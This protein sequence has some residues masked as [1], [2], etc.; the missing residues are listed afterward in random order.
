M[1]QNYWKKPIFV[2]AVSDDNL[3][4][5]MESYSGI[6][7]CPSGQL[8]KTALYWLLLNINRLSDKIDLS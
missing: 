3:L 7:P 8:F 5:L 6:P 4:H 2:I 1:L